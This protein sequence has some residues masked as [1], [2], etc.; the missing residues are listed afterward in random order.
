MLR[1]TSPT[2]KNKYDV[3]P[4]SEIPRGVEPIETEVEQWLSGAGEWLSIL[5]LI[6]YRV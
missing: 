6:G 5:L 2:Q 1:E 4:H 3:I